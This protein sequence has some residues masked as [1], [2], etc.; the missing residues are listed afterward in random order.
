MCSAWLRLFRKAALLSVAQS[1]SSSSSPSC[2][3]STSLSDA[4]RLANL[5]STLSRLESKLDRVISLHHE[6]PVTPPQSSLMEQ[7]LLAAINA[8][9]HANSQ[10]RADYEQTQAT[11]ARLRA[12]MSDLAHGADRFIAGL[13]SRLTN[14]ERDLFFALIASVPDGTS[15]RI[16][17]YAEIAQRRGVSKQAI[18]K[19]YRSLRAAHPS[20]GDYVESIR[21]PE[22]PRNFSE[23]SPT[24]RQNYGVDSAYDH[25]V[26]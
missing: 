22:T 10:M 7:R 19:A 25:P 17:S 15:R 24:D 20:V 18:H 26:G 11:A 12:S 1:Q 6:N 13:T 14:N 5:E 9:A 16:Q 23:L 3:I 21:H 2:T 4:D 8:L